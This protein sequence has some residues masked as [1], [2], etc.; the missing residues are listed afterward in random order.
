[1]RIQPCTIADLGALTEIVEDYHGPTED[2]H[3]RIRSDVLGITF[4]TWFLYDG[5]AMCYER[6]GKRK[7]QA[8]IYSVSRDK[9]GKRLR[10]FAVKAGR[11]MLD[12]TEV[13]TILNFVEPDRRDLMFF[14]RMIGSKK[15]GVIPGTNQILYVST[16]DMGIR[17]DI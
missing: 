5:M 12:N 8:H 2:F 17:E 1:M 11:W 4:G 7:A 10:D 9:R 14:M 6:I 16:G 3:L 13:T 15:V